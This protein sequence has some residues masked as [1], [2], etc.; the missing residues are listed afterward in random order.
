MMTVCSEPRGLRGAPM[1]RIGLARSPEAPSMARAAISGFLEHAMDNGP[2]AT[3]TLLV[4]EL[5]SNAVIHSDA[6]PSS[7]IL[8]RAALL[9]G[10]TLRV[11]VTDQGKGFTPSQREPV[12]RR[13]GYGLYLVDTQATAWGVEQNHGTCVWFEMP[14]RASQKSGE[15]SGAE[16]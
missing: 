15:K 12:E 5:V 9:G 7:E 14:I 16:A 4:S 8:L 13:G 6:L 3:A 10:R 11:E 1:L 2:L